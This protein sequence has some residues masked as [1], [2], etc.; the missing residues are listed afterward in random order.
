LYCMSHTWSTLLY[1]THLAYCI[2]CHTFGLLFCMSHTWPI[3]LYVTHLAYCIVCHLAYCIVCHTFGLLYVTH[4]AYCIV[5]HTL[6][7]LYC[8]SHTWPIV[9]YVTHLAYYIVYHTLVHLDQ[10]LR[11][12]LQNQSISQSVNQLCLK[13]CYRTTVLSHTPH[14][15]PSNFDMAMGTARLWATKQS[16]KLLFLSTSELQTDTCQ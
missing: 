12:F 4:L 3:V 10:N 7:L 14:H 5:C 15:L 16:I 8:M 2:V 6:G 1:V 9:L 11:K 13:W